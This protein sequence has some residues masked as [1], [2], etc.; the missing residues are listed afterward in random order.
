MTADDFKYS[1]ERA[2]DPKTASPVAANYL[3]D[4]KG[5]TERIQGKATDI[6]GVKVVDPHTLQITLNGFKPYWL[7][8]MTYPCTFRCLQ[9]G[10][11]EN[12]R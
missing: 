1:M 8:N 3:G 7:G 5:A 12:G 11:R 4:I 9:R 10:D 6:A 2:C